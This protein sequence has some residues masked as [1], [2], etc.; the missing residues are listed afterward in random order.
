MANFKKGIALALV[1]TTAFTFAPVSTLGVPNAV[2][3]EAA[4][5]VA[6]KLPAVHLSGANLDSEEINGSY[7]NNKKTVSLD[8]GIYTLTVD[9]TKEYASVKVTGATTTTA[10]GLSAVPKDF[11]R[12]SNMADAVNTGSQR[13][14]YTLVNGTG[15]DA[16]TVT[17]Y[18]VVDHSRDVTF[19]FNTNLNATSAGTSTFTLT[20]YASLAGAKSPEVV[21]TYA[22]TTT[23]ATDAG[24]EANF[25]TVPQATALKS[26]ADGSKYLPAS[27]KTPVAVANVSAKKW[28]GVALTGS[29]APAAYK[30]TSEDG[31]VDF[32]NVNATDNGN[33]TLT[34][35]T[36]GTAKVTV[37]AYDKALANPAK[38][39]VAS[40]TYTLN[41]AKGT[42][43]IT[44]ISYPNPA[45]TDATNANYWLSGP[46]ARFG[47]VALAPQAGAKDAANVAGNVTLDTLVTTSTKLNVIADTADITFKSEDTTIASVSADGTI[48]ANKAGNTFVDVFAAASADNGVAIAKIPVVVSSITKDVIKTTVDGKNV[49]DS[50]APV[51]LDLASCTAANAVKSAKIVATSAANFEVTYTLY[52]NGAVVPGN[53]DDGLT[54]LADGTV[55]AGT[56]KA[57]TTYTVK[58]TT[59]TNSANT[60]AGGEK[61]VKVVVNTLPADTL[62]AK[63]ITLDM[64]LNKTAT[65]EAVAGNGAAAVL[66]YVKSGDTTNG[67]IDG[68]ITLSG[69]KVTA[70]MIGKTTVTITEAAVAN[71]TRKTT[72]KINVIVNPD[73][74]KKVSDLTV[75]NTALIVESG[76]TAVIGAKAT[77]PI[78]YTSS[79]ETVATVA[80]DGTV[81]AV[82]PGQTTI[83]VKAA[84]SDAFVEGTITVPVVVAEKVAPAPVVDKPAKV[85]GVKIA[86]VKGAKVKVSFKK[87]S[88]A[89]GYV[90]TYKIGKKSYKK[91]VTATSVK[92]SVKK[93][94]KV[95]VTVK[96]FNYKNGNVKQYGAASK[97]VSKK[98][99]KK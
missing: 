7:T 90:V 95:K 74:V 32:S 52:K 70:N 96:A 66:S 92:L 67:E 54:L 75:E 51:D 42:S 14:S 85:T 34:P 38:K 53:K 12:D 93:G 18:F 77:N 1:A 37:T 25:D 80:A 81:T 27:V 10:A 5:N 46:A 44:A 40:T 8:D 61:D 29:T 98:T 47:G 64:T 49:N 13:G 76:K 3:A 63:D 11:V 89:A 84:G 83:I 68:V 24:V 23:A 39:V 31:K 59:K 69:A 4:A 78:T 16:K 91:T 19:T 35:N 55:T 20:K 21:A 17:E 56:V 28:T 79:D 41:V 9:S 60:I 86:N 88:K 30:W 73:T 97:A 6:I 36:S 65:I 43:N 62:D 2:V 22:V 50:T 72:K 57:D 26:A 48:T 94:A 99:D 71:K 82:K 58:V 15:T 33:V 87:V 45:A